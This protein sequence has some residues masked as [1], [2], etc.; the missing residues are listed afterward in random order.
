[1]LTAYW[2]TK[3]KAEVDFVIEAGK[4]IIPLEVKYTSLRQIK[5]PASIRS[6]IDKYK[7]N[8]AYLIN[9]ELNGSLEISKTTLFFLPFYELLRKDII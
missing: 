8:R 6:F 9:L 5:V 3:D 7:P 1:L 2:R 4:T